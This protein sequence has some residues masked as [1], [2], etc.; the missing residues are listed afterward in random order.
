MAQYDRAIPPGG[1][2]KITLIIDTN[3]VRGHFEKKT[4]IWSNDR[5]RMGIA[6]YLRGEVKPYISMEPGGY[7]SL[8]GVRGKVP[9]GHLEMINNTESP[10]KITSID[11]ELPDRV[12]WR[13]IEVKP[14]YIYGLEVED[15]SKI[16]GDYIG[17]LVVRTDNPKKPELT[18]VINGQI[19]AEE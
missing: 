9:Q 7:L 3:Q 1:K 12:R 10:V 15:I 6:L 8:W 17:H 16:A 2:G 18:I 14:G 13:L 11:N 5:E 4:M 19:K